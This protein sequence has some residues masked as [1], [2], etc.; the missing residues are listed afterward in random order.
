[1]PQ[2]HAN[3]IPALV[4]N[5][6]HCTD[7]LA[8]Q[9]A[10]LAAMQ[11]PMQRLSAV[12]TDNL[13]QIRYEMLANGWERKL[14]PAEVACFLSHQLAWQY[15]AASNQAMLILEDDALLSQ[16]AP[17]LL[18]ALA[19]NP[20]QADLITLETR[21]RKKL[22]SKA[23]LPAGQHFQLRRL[24]QDRTGAAAYVLYPQG[25]HKLLAKAQQRAPALADAFI[26][27]CYE[28][29]AWQVM[30]AAAIQLDQC[31]A[32][33][34]PFANP[35]AST[36]TP[37]D[38]HKPPANSTAMASLFKWRRISAQLK[39]GWRQLSTLGHSRREYM[40]IQTDDFRLPESNN[41]DSIA[42][43]KPTD[44]APQ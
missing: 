16:H 28:L 5:L 35:F 6:E 9:Q 8:F 27:S 24:Y 20:Q 2:S 26:S 10:Q 36:I 3:L 12:G 18:A 44:G 31:Q 13:D 32:Y 39:M 22:L 15:V 7:R 34:L 30:P 11:I 14:R 17:E 1:M 43:S 21:S 40:A 25:A 42:E 23:S 29:A 33:G 37:A 4:I 38:H 41:S 19:A